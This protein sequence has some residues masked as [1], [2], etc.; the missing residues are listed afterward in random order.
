MSIINPT[1]CDVRSVIRFLNTRN[2]RPAEIHRH[3]VE[4]Y[5]EGV[6][7]KGNM[8][9]LCRSFNRGRTVVQNEAR[10]GCPSVITQD[11]KGRVDAHVRENRRFTTDELHEVFPYVSR[12]VLYETVRVQLRYR[13]MA[14]RWQLMK[15]RKKPLWIG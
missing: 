13:K 15:K 5:G 7:N 3:L 14:N 6:M 2:I 1:D 4:V 9:K 11:L 12:S 10:S 8:R